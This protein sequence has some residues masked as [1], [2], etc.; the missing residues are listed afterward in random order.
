L[1]AGSGDTLDASADQTFIERPLG[2]TPAS[3]VARYP[4]RY[5]EEKI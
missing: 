4:E 5:P 2:K 3:Q 1:H